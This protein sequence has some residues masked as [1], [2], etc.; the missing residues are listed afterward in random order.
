[1]ASFIGAMSGLG[2]YFA[3]I[4]AIVAINAINGG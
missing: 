2:I 3:A 1:M 4:I